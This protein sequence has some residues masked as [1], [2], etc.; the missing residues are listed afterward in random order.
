VLFIL[1]IAY[2]E[3]EERVG[4]ISSP[5]GAKTEM[6]MK[7]IVD[8][9]AEFRISDIERACP[10]VGREWIRSRLADLKKSG[11]V[12]CYGKGPAARWRY[13]KSGGKGIKST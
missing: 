1:Q 2:R 6:V 13:Q 8:Q 4:Q 7:V 10:G 5:R 3:L 11:N 9:I 12:T